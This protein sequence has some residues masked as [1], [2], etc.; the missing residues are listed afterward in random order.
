MV[1]VV[2]FSDGFF[3]LV[4]IEEGGL[5]SGEEY[6]LGQPGIRSIRLFDNCFDVVLP[7]AKGF[8]FTHVGKD[9]DDLLFVGGEVF[10]GTSFKEEVACVDEIVDF[11]SISI[12]RFWFLE[13]TLSFMV[14][15]HRWVHGSWL[16]HIGNRFGFRFV[17]SGFCFRFRF[18]LI[19]E[20]GFVG[21]FKFVLVFDAVEGC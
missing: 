4:F 9:K 8:S 21:W 12:K 7:P 18:Q 20:Y 19:V 13:V 15:V 16:C 5:E 10:V 2:E 3:F 14:D 6:C 17:V 11:L 1:D